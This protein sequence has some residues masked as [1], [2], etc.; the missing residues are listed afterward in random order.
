M[1]R[2]P[3]LTAVFA[4]SCLALGAASAHAK[5]GER[6]PRVKRAPSVYLMGS[7]TMGSVL[8]PMLQSLIEKEWGVEARRWGKAS[9]GLARP[10]FHDWPGL[11]P[12][13]MDKHRPDI[14]VVSLGTNDNQ[15]IW[16]R[17][18]VWV[19][20][21]SP[22]WET[23][24]A[25]RVRETLDKA[26]GKD[27]RRL[28]IWMGPTAFEGKVASRQGP[29]INRIIKREV[30]AFAGKAIFVDSYAATSDGKGRPRKTFKAPGSKRE[31]AAFGDDGIHLTTEAVRWLLAEPVRQHIGACVALSKELAA[32]KVAEPEPEPEPD[33]VDAAPPD[34]PPVAD[35]TVDTDAEPG[36]AADETDEPTPAPETD[37]GD[38]AA[39]EPEPEPGAEP[40]PA[41]EPEP[42]AP[43]PAPAP[44]SPAEPPAGP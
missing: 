20:L 18:S 30:E 26:A 5:S 25:E 42:E 38:E 40:A 43:T 12:S 15:P 2:R 32:A 24:Y 22:K 7:S 6:C 16:V 14:V 11:L 39:A 28:V 10:D 21:D 31:Q 13:L 23:I 35:G 1:R 3:L 44:E 19:R 29:I 34:A 17:K 36:A 8:G 27:R 37:E 41:P 33:T 4:L 9:S